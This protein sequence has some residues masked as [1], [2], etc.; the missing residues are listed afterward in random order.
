[1]RADACNWT[2]LAVERGKGPYCSSARW[3]SEHERG[4]PACIVMRR[5]YV[6]IRTV[7][8]KS[9]LLFSFWKVREMSYCLSRPQD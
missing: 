4:I 6:P 9:A 8:E 2:V 5:T 1:M 7:S 3:S